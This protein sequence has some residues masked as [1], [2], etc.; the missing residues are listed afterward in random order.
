MHEDNILNKN[1][2]FK[3]RALKYNNQK[4]VLDL[5]R[6]SE[7]ITITD[8]SQ[9]IKL[10]KTTV[11]RIFEALE[12]KNLILK[13]G[14]GISSNNGGKRPEL[15]IF[16]NKF[17]YAIC[18][19]IL[20]DN[21]KLVVTDSKAFFEIEKIVKIRK[22]EKIEK[23]IFIISDFI[24]YISNLPEYIHRNLLG[25]SIATNGV[26]DQIN[27]LLLTSPRFP[28][29]KGV[30]P[31]VQ[32]IQKHTHQDLNIYIDNQ[33]RFLSLAE[34]EKGIGKGYKNILVIHSGA[35]GLGGGLY[36]NGILDHGINCLSGEIGHM[37]LDPFTT[38]KCKCGGT[39]CFETLGTSN[40][41]IEKAKNLYLLKPDSLYYKKSIVVEDLLS[42]YKE[43]DEVAFSI[44]EEWS[45]WFA[46]AISNISVVCDPELIVISNNFNDPDEIFINSIRKK[47][48]DISLT[49]MK[50][51]YNIMY[52]SFKDK[53]GILIGAAVYAANKY[54]DNFFFDDMI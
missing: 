10:S 45:N 47:V 13:T 15:Y 18:I 38:E 6:N 32:N 8:V 39:G 12:S 44:I 25:V 29:W 4:N 41:Y 16:N 50:K 5:F 36:F 31:I 1:T 28:S 7:E 20:H 30:V 26:T 51:N 33:N 52:T 2:G 34:Y 46:I 43:N 24:N 27:G 19:H 35:D 11:I 48:Y 37:R 21:I 3:P 42:A 53:K 22:D 14:K 17:G 40:R 54:F 23:I 49:I 9:K